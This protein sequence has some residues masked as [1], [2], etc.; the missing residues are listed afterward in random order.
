MLEANEAVVVFRTADADRNTQAGLLAERLRAAGIDAALAGEDD[1]G[2]VVGTCE[3][4]VAAADKA[5]AE[6]LMVSM[7]THLDGDLS[8]DMD[9]VT[10]FAADGVSAEMEALAIKGILDSVGIEAIVV[11]SAA[12]PNLPFEVQAPR[13]DAESARQAIDA[14][15][16]AGPAAAEEGA[17]ET[18]G[19][20]EPEAEVETESPGDPSSDLDMVCVFS[21]EG[22]SAEMQALAIKGI[23][24]SEG[25]ESVMV[26]S[27]SIPSLPFEVQVTRADAETALQAIE[28]AQ[29]AGPSAAEAG[30]QASGA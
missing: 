29:A 14:A 3:V 2:V 6:E 27:P 19:P 10:V 15:I 26:G 16:A 23:L 22:A 28:A 7:P 17:A 18:P 21:G 20:P 1:P 4:R 11:G 24:E 8:S 13:A 5:R 25:I 30:F 12:L 9:M